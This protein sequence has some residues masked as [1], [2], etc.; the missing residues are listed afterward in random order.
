M[1]PNFLQNILED[2]TDLPDHADGVTKD[3][4]IFGLFLFLNHFLIYTKS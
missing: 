4:L 3:C 1:R 2:I